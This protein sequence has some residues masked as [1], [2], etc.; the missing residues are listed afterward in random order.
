MSIAGGVFNAIL[1]GERIGCD[2]IQMFN[3]SNNRWRAKPL[4]DSEVERFRA[5]VARTGISVACSHA[6]YLINLATPD[7]SLWKKSVGS[8][9]EELERCERLGIAHL[10]VHPGAH[11]G[12][13]V[14]RGIERIA[15]A[16][17]E[18]LMKAPG[19][20]CVCLET[21]AGQGS[22]LGRSFEEIAAIMKL[23][24]DKTRVSVCVDTCHIF[25][26]GYDF[27]AKKEYD[28]TT[29]LLL[30]AIS[31]NRIAVFHCN[32]SKGDLGS[33]VDRHAHIGQGKI[34]L[35]GFEFLMNDSRFTA[36]PKILETPKGKDLKEDIANMKILRGLIQGHR[37]ATKTSAPRAIQRSQSTKTSM[38]SQ[39]P[40]TRSQKTTHAK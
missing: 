7:D 17:N 31:R 39:R 33:H 32:D 10:V 38:K 22:A 21:T 6:S 18:S 4:S 13:G 14:T 23:I 24:S 12:S 40:R 2:A 15:E 28:R 29:S 37:P 25:A 3:K 11:V 1:D 16:I 8:L 27:R 35:S 19:K 20:C 26:A 30:R 5:E 34:G 36:I 9:I